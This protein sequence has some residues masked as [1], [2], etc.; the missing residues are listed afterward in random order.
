VRHVIE[1]PGT[2]RP[3]SIDPATSRWLAWH[4]AV[5]HGLIGREVR[6][7]GDAVMLYDPNDR[8]PFWNRVA[9]IAWPDEPAAFD[10]RLL[11]FL[12]L[13]A[14][15]DRTPHV[16]PLPGL[17]EPRDLV[18]RLLGAGF[19]DT[20]AG[21]MMAF[22]PARGDGDAP[23]ERARPDIT[24]ERVHRIAGDEASR[25]ARGI[26]VVLAEAFNVE[27]YRIRAIEEETLTLLGLDAF[28]AVLVRIDGEPAATAR[29]TTF[30]GAS[31]LSSIGTRPAFQGRGLGR[32]ATEAALADAIAAGSRW[33]Y[34]G[35]FD[36]NLVA[37]RMYEA[38]GFEMLGGP[39]P[40]LI[41]R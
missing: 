15:L 21:L 24:V 2:G 18:D 35:V 41:L 7:L 37:R 23:R 27:P 1:A 33:T 14:S 19:R 36:D 5:S 8:E 38:L 4:E 22:D 32:V 34:L 30:A 29:R 6:P 3:G 40:D 28:N 31:Y 26:A 10:R 20:G 39:A 16:W 9:G 13:F 11:E 17:D 12:A 25:A